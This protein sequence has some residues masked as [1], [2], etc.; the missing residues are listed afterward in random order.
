MKF[1]YTTVIPNNGRDRLEDTS[2]KEVL[3]MKSP[4]KSSKP[5]ITHN[6]YRYI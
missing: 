5:T 1:N 3:E 6:T 4:Q 2:K